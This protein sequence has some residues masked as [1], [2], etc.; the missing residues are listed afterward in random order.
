M[1][2]ISCDHHDIREHWDGK[3]KLMASDFSKA[4]QKT[5]LET[6]NKLMLGDEPVN[7]PIVLME[8]I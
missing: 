6:V 2:T 5:V 1:A 3:L 7:V 8:K 4:E